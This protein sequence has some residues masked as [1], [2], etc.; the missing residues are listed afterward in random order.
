MWLQIR[1]HYHGSRNGHTVIVEMRCS[2][3]SQPS[4]SRPP[5]TR[6][7][8]A[9]FVRAAMAISMQVDVVV[10]GRDDLLTT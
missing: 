3:G 5:T 7:V 4:V 2:D 6:T 1:T 10:D 9:K 8:L